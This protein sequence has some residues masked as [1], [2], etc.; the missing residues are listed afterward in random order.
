M[1]SPKGD[2]ESR[3][4]SV[5]VGSSFS[6]KLSS[7]FMTVN[8]VIS[9][10][11]RFIFIF[12]VFIC[13]LS[14]TIFYNYRFWP[15]FLHNYRFWIN[16]SLFNFFFFSKNCNWFLKRIYRVNFSIYFIMFCYYH[17]FAVS[18]KWILSHKYRLI[19]SKIR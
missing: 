8:L 4:V 11:F 1:Y 3:N 10:P 2:G 12:F 9:D 7:D 14:Y 19:R 18:I 16:F 15:N 13:F 17:F 5:T 6:A